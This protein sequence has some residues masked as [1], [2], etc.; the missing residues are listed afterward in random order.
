MPAE[1]LEWMRKVSDRYGYPQILLRFA[2]AAGLNGRPNEARDTLARICR[3]H[4]LKRCQ[5]ARE[6]W[7]ALQ[8]RNPKLLG[9]MAPEIPK[10]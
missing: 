9:V 8:A 2:L 6:S 7:M 3:I 10:N 1:R 4:A 5:E